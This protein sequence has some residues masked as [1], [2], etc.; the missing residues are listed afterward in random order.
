MRTGITGFRS[1]RGKVK[2]IPSKLYWI[3]IGIACMAGAPAFAQTS[4]GTPETYYKDLTRTQSGKENYSEDGRYIGPAANSAAVARRREVD[5]R[6]D[7]YMNQGEEGPTAY[8][9][10][11]YSPEMVKGIIESAKAGNRDAIGPMGY[12]YEHGLGVERNEKMAAEWYKRAIE[13]GD[14]RYYSSIGNLYRE[15]NQK[16]E[17]GFFG[18]IRKMMGT[19]DTT[20]E[21][22]D[23][24]AR[25]WYE[26]G[27]R[28]GIDDPRAYIELGTMYRSGVGGLEKDEKKAK[29]YHEN[30]IRLKQRRDERIRKEIEAEAR[31]KIEQELLGAELAAKAADAPQRE[32][33]AT[34][35]Q[36]LQAMIM[37]DGVQCSYSR[38][39]ATQRGYSQTFTVQCPQTSGN[40]PQDKTVSMAGL[41]C[42]IARRGTTPSMLLCNV[43][44]GATLQIGGANCSLRKEQDEAGYAA[45]YGAYCSGAANTTVETVDYG[46]TSCVVQNAAAA[47]G[48][49]YTLKCGATDAATATPAPATPTIQQRL[50]TH[51]CALRQV[52]SPSGNYKLVYEAY[53]GG[54]SQS[55]KTSGAVPGSVSIGVSLCSVEPWPENEE[56]KDFELYCR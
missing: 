9:G 40:R 28:H 35:P 12:L 45:I 51:N 36:N 22:D 20:L 7:A 44:T 52:D 48:K 53:C 37:V 18:Q 34:Q 15:T 8:D 5:K 26:K 41:E 50:G 2:M 4:G 31:K 25:Q 56:K 14:H 29:I 42:D 33:P 43:A 24:T 27:L 3:G 10:H 13:Y 55:Q 38:A 19:D 47:S 49:T 16:K 21:K 17:T 46:G 30:G 1:D 32:A 54:L 23:V 6:L 39:G 11:M